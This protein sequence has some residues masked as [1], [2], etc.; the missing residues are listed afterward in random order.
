MVYRSFVD[1]D[2]NLDRIYHAPLDDIGSTT[3][4][5]GVIHGFTSTPNHLAVTRRLVLAELQ[6][7]AAVAAFAPG[8]FAAIWSDAVAGIPQSVH[9]VD[10]FAYW[11]DFAGTERIAYGSLDQPA[12]WLRDIA[13]GHIRAFGTDGVDLA[14]V[15]IRDSPPS[16]E[17]W[18]APVVFDAA[19]LRPRRVREVQGIQFA[20]VGGGWFVLMKAE[21][22]R[23]EIIELASGRTKTWLAPPGYVV[24]ATGERPN[25]VTATEIVFDALTP[26][27]AYWVRLDPRTVP[28]DE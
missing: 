2:R 6:P 27:G 22:Q 9:G 13:P 25:Y 4:P 7:V 24:T 16:L 8:R 5:I 20:G 10:D 17:L 26:D 3:E 11:L 21:P 23:L 1:A 14:W 28:W 18:T 15:E 12:A 19:A